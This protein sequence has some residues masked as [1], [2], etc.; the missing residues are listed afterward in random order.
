M[1]VKPIGISGVIGQG[2][3]IITR[4][5]T[6]DRK[7]HFMSVNVCVLKLKPAISFMIL[8]SKFY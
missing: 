4:R 2:S 6:E 8:K 1:G 3:M 5:L 7:G